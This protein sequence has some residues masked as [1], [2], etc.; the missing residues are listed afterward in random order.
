MRTH[1]SVGF[2]CVVT[3][4][5]LSCGPSGTEE[6]GQSTL[7][8]RQIPHPAKAPDELDV[9]GRHILFLSLRP[10]EDLTL[11]TF[12]GLTN[13]PDGT[14]LILTVRSKKIGYMAQ[15]EVTVID[16][17][18]SSNKFSKDGSPLIPGIYTVDISSPLSSLQPNSVNNIVGIEYE[19]FV[20]PQFSEAGIG[21]AIDTTTRFIVPGKLTPQ[22]I[23]DAKQKADEDLHDWMLD[24]CAYI[25]KLTGRPT[26]TDAAQA[27]I[28]ACADRT[29]EEVKRSTQT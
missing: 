10:S 25:E 8:A 12:S 29:F 5:L 13:L 24:S 2:A 17:K 26:K 21:R 23:A 20:G 19:N 4:G 14:S 16:N 6:N 15:D 9:Q 27:K 22:A 28:R 3:L 7:A 1:M 18:F 11:P